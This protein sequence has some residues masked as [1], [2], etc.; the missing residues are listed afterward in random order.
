M[1]L[2]QSL[3]I[4]RQ[5]LQQTLSA[6]TLEAVNRPAELISSNSVARSLKIGDM[7]PEF[8]LP[9]QNGQLIEIKKLL[10]KGSVVI[11]FYRGIWCRFCSLELKALQQ[12][13]PAINT[14]GGTLVTIS[15]QI[16]IESYSD[17]EEFNFEILA[18]KR[19]KVARQFG[20]VFQIP[21]KSRIYYENLG[22]YIPRYNGD[23]TFELPIPATL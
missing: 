21:E 10:E 7:I 2:S 20:I 11:S 12:A 5:N 8:S 17:V 16:S 1:D 18:D 3:K 9:N 15:P 14:L 4:A 22:F 19:N 13:L 6:E 23:E